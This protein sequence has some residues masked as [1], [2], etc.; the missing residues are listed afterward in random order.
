[1][2]VTYFNRHPSE[3]VSIRRVF[4][5]I[6]AELSNE[7]DIKNVSSVKSGASLFQ[8]IRNLL[9]AYR[10]RHISGIYHLTGANHYLSIVLPKSRTI[11]TVHD[12]GALDNHHFSGLKKMFWNLLFVQTLR[13]NRKIVCISETTKKSLFRY[14][15]VSQDKVVV[16]PDPISPEFHYI[17]KQFNEN[18]PVVLHVGTKANKNL[19]R[20][21]EALKGLNVHLRIIG[22][23][24]PQTKQMLEL[25]GINYACKN[26]ISDEELVLEYVNCDI[27]NFPSLYEGFGMPIIEAQ[28]VGRVCITSDLPPMN[29]VA[30]KGAYLV[31]P[32]EISSIR[33]AFVNIIENPQLRKQLI[34]AG[35]QNV[36]QYHPAVIAKQYYNLYREIMM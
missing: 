29:A 23:I 10:N 7:V 14:L 4:S 33:N 32:L 22:K 26:N 8:I 2:R 17:P 16:I 31:N 27:V 9:N 30:G 34:D 6:Q 21:I 36:M 35:L 11:T 24:S 3:G 28:A 15:N 5:I 20:T 13:R 25:S 18:T 1:M 19:D 12:F